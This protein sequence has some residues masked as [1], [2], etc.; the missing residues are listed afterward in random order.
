MRAVQVT[1]LDGPT[2]VEIRDIPEPEAIGPFGPVV[3]IEVKA[4]G[5]SFPD[6]LLSKGMYQLKPEP[7]FTLGVDAAGVVR[8][9]PEGSGLQPG[10]RVATCTGYGA[11]AELMAAGP[12][13]VFKLPHNITFEQA[14]AIPMNYMTAEFALGLRGQLQPGERVLVHGAAGGVGTATIQVA[15]A[16]GAETVAVVSSDA[17]ADFVRSVGADHVVP[18]DGFRAAVEEI[19]KVNVVMDVVGGDAFLDSLRVLDRFGRLLVVGFAAGGIP[20]VKVNRL[21][22]NNIDVRGAAWGEY[23][24]T[25]PGYLHKQWQALLPMMESGLVDPP[26][27]KVYEFDDFGQALVEMDERRTLGKS[28]VTV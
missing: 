13:A 18:L 12:D 20:E 14:A 8:S 1:R 24:M 9:A 25:T 16:M 3:L 22:L 10:D 11:A 4:I 7:P 15:K 26:I 6:L 28:V 21:L 5:V 19:G 27:G 17:K 23:A 2:A